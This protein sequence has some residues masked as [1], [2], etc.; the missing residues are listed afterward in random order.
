M[1]QVIVTTNQVGAKMLKTEI[2]EFQKLEINSQPL[3][4]KNECFM[5]KV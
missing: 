1:D 5:E 4:S 3:W 2:R